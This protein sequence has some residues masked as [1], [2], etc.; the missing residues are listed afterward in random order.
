MKR[1]SYITEK[2][3]NLYFTETQLKYIYL[4]ETQN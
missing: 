1:N 2:N 4:T 3:T